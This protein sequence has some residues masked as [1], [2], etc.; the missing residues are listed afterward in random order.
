MIG[1]ASI[2]TNLAYR[3][4]QDL[5]KISLLGIQ[6]TNASSEDVLEFVVDSLEKETKPY[7]IVTPNPEIVM[8]AR[9]HKDFQ[10]VIN[11]AKIALVDGVGLSLSGMI[12]GKHIKER[13]TGVDF[14]EKICEK[15]ADRPITAGFLG[16]RGKI[17]E[18]AS[19][20][21]KQKFPELKIVYV[22]DEWENKKQSTH[23]D[24]LFVAFGFPKQELWMA[25]HSGKVDV[26]VMIGVGGS[27]DYISGQV[28]RAP[29]FL[30][31][32]GLEWLFRLIRQPW[33]FKRQLALLSF[34]WTVLKEKFS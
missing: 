18:M 7:Y 15:I 33:R 29:A 9:R 21:L 13:F 2:K 22:S 6:V 23:I 30:R 28:K 14:V 16:G 34:I 26:S 11:N 20:C 31:A 1:N 4:S 12:L 10:Q 17:A 27:L 24:I 32:I 8:F 5:M 19:E 25:E 3:K